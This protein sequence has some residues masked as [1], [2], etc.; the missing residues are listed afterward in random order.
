VIRSSIEIDRSPVDVFAY[1]EQLDRHGEWQPAIVSA[2]KEPA[3]PTRAIRSPAMATSPRNHAAPVP[4]MTRPFS[5]MTS[6]AETGR[7]A[8]VD[9]GVQAARARP[10][11]RM[12]W[13][14]I[15]DGD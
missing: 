12:T 2:R 1:V 8:V 15:M 10:P 5:R 13:R 4:S 14:N 6:K 11:N 3:G 7:G 9:D